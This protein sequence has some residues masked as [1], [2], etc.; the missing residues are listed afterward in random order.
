MKPVILISSVGRRSQLISCMRQSLCAP[1]LAGCV[2]GVD[3]SKSAPG[4]YLVDEFS[5]PR[6]A[7]LRNCCRGSS[8]SAKTIVSPC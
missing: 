8:K 4:G 1:Q 7:M 6:A 2:L 5:W 3:C